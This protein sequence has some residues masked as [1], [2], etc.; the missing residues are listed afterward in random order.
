MRLEAKTEPRRESLRPFQGLD[1]L[2]ISKIPNFLQTLS[3]ATLRRS[4]LQEV[5]KRLRG[6][7]EVIALLLQ[8]MRQQQLELDA[9]MWC[10]VAFA[11]CLPHW[12]DDLHVLDT[13]QY[14]CFTLQSA[15]RA[16]WQLAPNSLSERW[17]LNLHLLQTT[18][19]SSAYDSSKLINAFARGSRWHMS[20]HVLQSMML[21][22]IKPGWQKKC[23][24]GYGSQWWMSEGTLNPKTARCASWFYV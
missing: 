7:E 16:L 23:T 4:Q 22:Q 1:S 14:D 6:N 17:S 15:M 19:H 3:L 10:Q 9:K 8:A 5:I 20:L 11:R 24:K 21:T 2:P 12:A 18:W 13:L